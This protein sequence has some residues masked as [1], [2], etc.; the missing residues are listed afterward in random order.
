LIFNNVRMVVDACLDGFGLACMPENKVGECL[1]DGGLI[2]ALGE[3]R[4]RFAGG[5]RPAGGPRYGRKGKLRGSP[6]GPDDGILDAEIGDD[7]ASPSREHF[8]P[9]FPPIINK[10]KEEY[11]L[12]NLVRRTGFH[13]C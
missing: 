12:R 7:G 11:L 3:W 13:L 6:G 9:D 2:K 4:P 10:N 5:L 8:R 1:A